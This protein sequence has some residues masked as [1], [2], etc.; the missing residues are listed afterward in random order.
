[1][2]TYDADFGPIEWSS[3]SQQQQQ[4]PLSVAQ[5]PLNVAQQ[6]LQAAW[7]TG[8]YMQP[9][10][11]HRQSSHVGKGLFS[12]MEPAGVSGQPQSFMSVP[13]SSDTNV[14]QGM[15]GGASNMMGGASNMMGGATNM[16]GG[17]S[18]MMGGA[19][20]MMGGA[21]NMMGGATNMMGGATNTGQ[22]NSS[23]FGAMDTRA[24][25]PEAT[26]AAGGMSWSGS[27]QSS[28]S[29][30]FSSAPQTG[31]VYPPLQA[32]GFQ[33]EQQYGVPKSTSTVRL[34]PTARPLPGLGQPLV[35]VPAQGSQQSQ[36]NAMGWSSG[37]SAQSSTPLQPQV[38]MPQ[39]GMGWSSGG[40]AQS[41]TPLQPQ[42]PMPKNVM[43][44]SSGS[45]A[46]SSTPQQ[47]QVTTPQ[48]GMG[49]SSGG[50]TQSSTPQR[51]QVTT[52]QNGMGWS[53]GVQQSQMQ[54]VQ[55][56]NPMVW[57]S[58]SGPL[59]P[60]Q[61]TGMAIGSSVPSAQT[62]QR[63]PAQTGQMSNQRPPPPA[64]DNPFADFIA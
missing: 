45:S 6:P 43:G 59:Q 62:Q 19:S 46:Q 1:M 18:N 30:Q 20:N 39:N 32:M 36:Q 12:G 34:E 10:E 29:N 49:W 14:K 33:G 22:S 24:P 13:S 28:F 61:Q 37:G 21:S 41:S 48:N 16:M 25:P 55:P 52:P 5:Q 53:S 40:S 63:P 17:A 51:S 44:W 11:D 8:Q 42:V 50:S 47:P 2:L 58:L 7:S 15:M 54:P 35:P 4:Q 26:T 38:P 64:R 27:G 9:P 3:A 31:Q 56:S 60:T 57:S 23:L